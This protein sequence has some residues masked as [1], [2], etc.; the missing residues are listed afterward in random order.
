[1]LEHF[2]LQKIRGHLILAIRKND[3]KKN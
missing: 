1:M 2:I 3:K